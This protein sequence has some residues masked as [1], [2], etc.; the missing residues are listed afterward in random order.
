M[1]YNVH[2]V[3]K[4]IVTYHTRKHKNVKCEFLTMIQNFVI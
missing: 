3:L 4:K 2:N 1:G